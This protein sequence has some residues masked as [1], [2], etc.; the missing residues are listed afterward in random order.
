[1]LAR[2]PLSLACHRH[3][4]AVNRQVQW[5]IP[6]AI[7]D[8]ALQRPLAP[9]QRPRVG[10]RL[11]QDDQAT[12]AFDEPGR[13]SECHPEQ[14]LHH[15]TCLDRCIVVIGMEATLAGWGCFLGHGGIQPDRQPSAPLDRFVMRWPVP[16]LVAGEMDLLVPSSYHTG[17][18]RRNYRRVCAKGPVCSIQS[19]EI[20]GMASFVIKSAYGCPTSPFQ[21]GVA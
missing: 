17:F 6:S 8:V 2:V 4:C 9:R 11:V 20:L 15:Q 1:M 10:Y 19:T 5:A 3:P 7:G 21:T 12:K 16:G 13:L 14:Y 18:T